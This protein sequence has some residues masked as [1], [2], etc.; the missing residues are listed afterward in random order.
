MQNQTQLP[1]HKCQPG[2]CLCNAIAT[3]IQCP[4]LGSRVQA[5]CK[6]WEYITWHE[7]DDACYTY[8]RPDMD[9]HPCDATEEAD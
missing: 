2:H 8:W 3:V 5:Y 7:L 9:P 6:G 4:T 1:G